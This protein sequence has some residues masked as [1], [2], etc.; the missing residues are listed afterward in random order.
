MTKPP[1]PDDSPAG[2]GE[3]GSA[4][5]ASRSGEDLLEAQ[6]TRLAGLWALVLARFRAYA[7]GSGEATTNPNRHEEGR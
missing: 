3:L 1:A 7:H 4:P 6:R 5:G 2:N